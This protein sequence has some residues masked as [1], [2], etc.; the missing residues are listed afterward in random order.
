MLMHRAIIIGL[1]AMRVFK[2]IYW[3]WKSSPSL[4]QPANQLHSFESSARRI[5]NTRTPTP[6][7]VNNLWI[8]SYTSHVRADLKILHRRLLWYCDSV[9]PHVA[10]VP[11][12]VY[13]QST[14][15]QDCL[16]CSDSVWGSTSLQSLKPTKYLVR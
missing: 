11:A 13:A 8:T 7:T 12:G 1:R 6:D 5:S 3:P 16:L 4:S 14:V 2:G 9:T 10:I 15:M